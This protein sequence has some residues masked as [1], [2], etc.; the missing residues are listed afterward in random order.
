MKIFKSTI[1][2][3]TLNCPYI[4]MVCSV[5]FD[6]RHIV[7]LIELLLEF[8]TLHS[9]FNMLVMV[10]TIKPYREAMLK[11][12]HIKRFHV[13]KSQSLKI[14]WKRPIQKTEGNIVITENIAK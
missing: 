7:N 2:V 10:I 4:L 3:L 14:F 12:L 9:T 8:S 6:F 1:P 11:M 5:A 13:I